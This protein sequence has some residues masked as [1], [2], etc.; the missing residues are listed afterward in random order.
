MIPY[1]VWASM[2]KLC[3]YDVRKAPIRD[4][5]ISIHK[6]RGFERQTTHTIV[7]QKGVKR[8]AVNQPRPKFLCMCKASPLDRA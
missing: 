5:V 2:Q 6:T 8:I 1:S 7:L 3:A 4:L